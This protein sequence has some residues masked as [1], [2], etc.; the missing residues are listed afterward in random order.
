MKNY[1]MLQPCANGWIVRRNEWGMINDDEMPTVYVFNSMD[2]AADHIVATVGEKRSAVPL[3]N[4]KRPT[5]QSGKRN[6]HPKLPKRDS[7][8]HFLPK[9]KPVSTFTQTRTVTL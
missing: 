5:S 9:G 2:K 1:F 3:P 6:G 8:G 4:T 7:K